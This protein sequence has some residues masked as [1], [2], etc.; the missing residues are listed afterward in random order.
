MNKTSLNYLLVTI[1]AIVTQVFT[2]NLTALYTFD[3][4]PFIKYLSS[5]EEEGGQSKNVHL[6]FL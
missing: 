1:Y 2:Q 5:K 4:G 6:L 3:K